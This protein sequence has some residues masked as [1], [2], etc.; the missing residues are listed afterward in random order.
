MEALPLVMEPDSR[1]YEDPVAVL[2][3]QSLYPSIVIAY[4]LCYST[5]LGRPEHCDPTTPDLLQFGV[6]RCAQPRVRVLAGSSEWLSAPSPGSIVGTTHKQMH[7]RRVS[8]T[9]W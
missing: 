4:N 1:F 9:F 2:D 7:C 5:C 8:G 3:F 6:H